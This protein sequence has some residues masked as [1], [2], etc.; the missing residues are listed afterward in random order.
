MFSSLL[1]KATVLAETSETIRIFSQYELFISSFIKF[2]ICQATH[3][4]FLNLMMFE[5][6][7][8][9][10]AWSKLGYIFLPGLE[11]FFV[12]VVLVGKAFL[13][14]KNQKIL[15]VSSTL[16]NGSYFMFNFGY[17]FRACSNFSNFTKR[18]H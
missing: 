7:F 15:K 9:T 6:F 16:R 12:V 13:P 11:L 10:L 3:R 4:I 18:V 5:P 2:L 1:R 14:V 17:V 8:S